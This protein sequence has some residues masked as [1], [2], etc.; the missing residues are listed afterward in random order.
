MSKKKSETTKEPPIKELSKKT[1][2]RKLNE[3]VLTIIKHYLKIGV[4]II[5]ICKAVKINKQTFYNWKKQGEEDK[6][7]GIQ[8]LEFDLVDSLMELQNYALI[9]HLENVEK[10]A[11]TGDL[12][13]SIFYLKTRYPQYFSEN[14][15]LRK[16]K[17]KSKTKN[18][19]SD[20]DEITNR[21]NDKL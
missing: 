19:E 2:A 11:M 20:L 6:K 10:I 12:K 5:E 21:L 7:N 1:N 16:T 18:V 13:A 15:E 8:S 17:S 4:P 9:F 3:K 14:P